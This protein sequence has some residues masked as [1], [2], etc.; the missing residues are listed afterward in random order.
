[1]AILLVNWEA[2]SAIATCVASLVVIIAL[3]YG[4]QQLREM[5]R[6]RAVTVFLPLFQSLQTAAASRLRAQ[7]Y[8][9]VPTDLSGI[10]PE[11]EA[12]MNEV[13]N[14]LDFLGFLTER[15]L[16]EFELIAP[17]FYGTT[18]RCWR[19]LE[20]YVQAQRQLRKTR[21]AWYF[22]RL[23]IRCEQFVT[24]SRP[25]EE[26]ALYQRPKTI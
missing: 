12:I 20:P 9:D 3:I 1:M 22:E 18:I 17:F 15:N 19:R 2:I 16:I 11:H 10:T 5:Q 24:D 21:F 13:I 7:I 23:F 26:I 14:Q 8:N 25:E 6:T 4:M